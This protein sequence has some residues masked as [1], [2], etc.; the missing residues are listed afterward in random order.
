MTGDEDFATCKASVKTYCK[1]PTA[2]EGYLL[3]A[4][5]EVLKTEDSNYQ[6]ISACQESEKLI[7]RDS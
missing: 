3:T 6:V 5:N 2:H 1:H 7:M 4:E